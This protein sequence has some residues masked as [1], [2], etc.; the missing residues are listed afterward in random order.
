MKRTSISWEALPVFLQRASERK[1]KKLRIRDFFLLPQAASWTLRLPKLEIVG[2]ET[3]T[4][5]LTRILLGRKKRFGRLLHTAYLIPENLEGFFS[6]SSQA[7]LRKSSNAAK[8]DGY[9]ASWL[10][11]AELLSAVNVVLADRQSTKGELT[12]EG[13]YLATR[14]AVDELE[15]VVVFSPAGNPVSVI[16]GLRLEGFFLH[17]LAVGSEQGRPRWLAFATLISESHSRGVRIILGERVW[18]MGRGDILF[19]ER[20]GFSPVN[21]RFVMQKESPV[22]FRVAIR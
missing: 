16:I 11:G 15:G 7:N 21:L 14:V 5:N 8:R 12:A 10:Q 20:L 9:S 6:G 2:S 22:R 1:V 13:L 4:A 17:R 3:D 19:Q 18:A